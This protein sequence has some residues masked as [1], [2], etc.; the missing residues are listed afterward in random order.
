MILDNGTSIKV[1]DQ[2]GDKRFLK[3]NDGMIV[4]GLVGE[5]SVRSLCDHFQL[6]LSLTCIRMESSHA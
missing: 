1:G 4:T 6:E 5:I 2:A 3:V